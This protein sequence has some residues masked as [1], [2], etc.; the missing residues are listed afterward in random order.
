MDFKFQIIIIFVFPPLSVG[1]G[2]KGQAKVSLGCREAPYPPSSWLS[3][4]GTP[5][6]STL[7]FGPGSRD[8]FLDPATPRSLFYKGPHLEPFLH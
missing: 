1:R 7:L 8:S 4:A 6:S 3:E 2:N 5:P